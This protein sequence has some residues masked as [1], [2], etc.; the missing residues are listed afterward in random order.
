[1]LLDVSFILQG[2]IRQNSQELWKVPGILTVAE[3]RDCDREV[4]RVLSSE[5]SKG[6]V[7]VLFMLLETD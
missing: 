6:L 7:Y 2:E 1:M 5:D 4:I 3:R